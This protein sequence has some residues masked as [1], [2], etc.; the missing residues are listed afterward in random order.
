MLRSATIFGDPSPNDLR[1]LNLLVSV[2]QLFKCIQFLS[3]CSF[4]YFS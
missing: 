2:L 4:N 1:N 3:V